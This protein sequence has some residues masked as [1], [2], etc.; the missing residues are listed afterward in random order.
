MMKQPLDSA[1]LVARTI[2]LGAEAFAF[3]VIFGAIA[4][5]WIRTH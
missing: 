1:D 2:I 4:V 3:I 5:F